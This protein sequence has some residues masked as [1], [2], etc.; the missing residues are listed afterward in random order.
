M[1][2]S[3]IVALAVMMAIL[4]V[5]P[6]AIAGNPQLNFRTHLSGDPAGTDSAGQ[7]EAIVRFSDDTMYFKVNVANIENVTMAH[8]HVAAAPGGDGPPVVWLY[9]AGPPPL[10]IEG[11]VQGRLGEGTVTA[12]DLVGPL[13]GMTL[14]DLREAILDGRA[15]VNVHTTQFPGG[16]IR[17]QF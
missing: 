12:A 15:Y 1:R 16:E 17:G 14:E 8:I 11:R 10:L 4:V 3:F 6:A 7:G 9:P 5:A 13:A 2:R